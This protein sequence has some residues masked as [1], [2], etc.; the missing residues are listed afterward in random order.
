MKSR[1]VL[2]LASLASMFSAGILL[3]EEGPVVISNK[4]LEVRADRKTGEITIFA[5]GKP[6]L[7]N[8]RIGT[9]RLRDKDAVTSYG[10]RGSHGGQINIRSP[11]FGNAVGLIPDSPFALVG[12]GIGNRTKAP[13]TV[14]KAPVFRGM[15]PLTSSPDAIKILGTGGLSRPGKRVGSYM[16]LTVAEPHRRSGIVAGFVT[17]DRGSG[18]LFAEDKDGQ[19]ELDAQVDL[20]QRTIA[21]RVPDGPDTDV[22]LESFVIGYF[23]DVRDGLE[24]WANDVARQNK[25]K[26]SPQPSGYCTWYHAGASNE[27][28]MVKQTEFA[29]KE[30]KPYGF[31]FI[32]IDD[33]WQ[34]GVK[35]NGPRKNFTRIRANGPYP[36]GMKQ[37]A[38]MIRSH[39]LTPG[40]WFMPFAGTYNDP[41]FRDHQDWFA[42][43][44]DGSP[45]DTAWGGTCMDMTNPD[46]RKYLHDYVHQI[47]HDWG[48]RY[49]KMDGLSTG[50]AVTPQYVNLAYK[51]DHMGDAVFHDP[52]KTNIE[53]FRSGLKLVREA[54]GP[55]VFLLGCCAR[56]TC[57]AMAGQWGW[58]MPCASGPTIMAKAGR[59]CSEGRRSPRGITTSMA[60][61][62]TTTPTRFTS[63]THSRSIR[64][65]RT[66]HG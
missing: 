11:E 9:G 55:D 17:T 27:Q 14:N 58:S 37:T 5:K 2:L 20:G 54:A 3:A 13:M 30:L 19:L 31:D 26:L 62:G 41:W 21:P 7:T 60:A 28:A 23:D 15:F 35:I 4:Y 52:T 36:S 29:A 16:W 10:G 39:G 45:Y 38:E 56:R 46:A 6:I 51:D 65:V 59:A 44:A 49:L 50:A 33:G 61:S 57:E 22:V 12:V 48:Y 64:P 47:T 18:V 42:K 34:D 66:P 43:R 32:Q 53:A 25:V 8:V 24:A 63:A 40:V 1:L